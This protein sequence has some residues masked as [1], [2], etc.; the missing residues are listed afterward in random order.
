MAIEKTTKYKVFKKYQSLDNGVTWI[1]VEPEEA[2]YMAWEQNS[3]DCGY[4]PPIKPDTT[5]STTGDTGTTT[6]ETGCETTYSY[7]G[8]ERKKKIVG[9]LISGE[10]SAYNFISVHLGNCVT[11]LGEYSLRGSSTTHFMSVYIPNSVKAI[12]ENALADNTKLNSIKIPDSVTLIANYAFRNCTAIKDIVIPESTTYIGSYAFSYCTSLSSVTIKYQ[13][14]KLNYNEAAFEKISSTAKLYV[15]SNLLADYQS[16]TSWTDAFKGGIYSIE[17]EVSATGDTGATIV[18]TTGSTTDEY[19]TIIKY[20][21]GS[22]SGY[23]I[24]GEFKDCPI[25]NLKSATDVKIGSGV[26]RIGSHSF[27]DNQNLKTVKIPDTVKSIGYYS[28]YRC[29]GLS[30]ITIPDSVT[31]I[32]FE[33]F[34]DC[35]FLYEITIPYS[36]ASIGDSSFVG[37][38]KLSTIK[39]KGTISQWNSIEKGKRWIGCI[40][41][42]CTPTIIVHCTDG[43]I[44]LSGGTITY[45]GT[46]AQ[47]SETKVE[48]TDN[49]AKSYSLNGTLNG[50]DIDNRS[51]AVT[52]SIGT[53]ITAIGDS[54]FDNWDNLLVIAIPNSVT[55]F[56]NRIFTGLEK[57]T[58]LTIPSSV[59]NIG[60]YIFE[61]STRITEITYQGTKTEWNAITKDTNWNNES[62]LKTIHCTDGDI[63]L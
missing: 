61:N 52:V 21:D 60:A 34:G 59:K 45:T 62:E 42:F 12:G 44:N 31:N 56:G 53:G 18:V 50:M 32:E 24:N 58:T 6:G 10:V 8:F 36:V 22:I 26:T 49:S 23:T 7:D 30:A 29:W 55:T 16:N 48:Y 39:Y 9:E 54:C 47:I 1:L 2:E 14:Y 3:I 20:K 25:L 38:L 13:G 19:N 43:F 27:Y 28:F 41:N 35:R 5:G 33:A 11:S 17:E 63:T 57:L 40:G 4:I 15:P 37:S 46:T 51:S